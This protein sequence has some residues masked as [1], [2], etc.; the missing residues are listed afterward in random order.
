MS[1]VL[2]PCLFHRAGQ[3][4]AELFIPDEDLSSPLTALSHGNHLSPEISHLP[5]L[6]PGESGT[7]N[8]VLTKLG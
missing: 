4:G 1:C 7:F 5:F 3:C 6:F 8:L 2:V